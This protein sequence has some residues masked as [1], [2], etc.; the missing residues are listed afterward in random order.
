MSAN[1]W[2]YNEAGVLQWSAW[3]G[4]TARAMA[5]DSDGNV[6]VVGGRGGGK[7]VWKFDEDGNE[8]DS[9]DTGNNTAGCCLDGKGHLYVVGLQVSGKAVWKLDTSDMSLVWSVYAGTLARCVDYL[10]SEI[11]V[12]CHPNGTPVRDLR[13]FTEDGEV[14]YATLLTAGGIYAIKA[15]NYLWCGTL[16]GAL[17]KTNR[18]TG[19]AI[20]SYAP[21][22]AVYAV[23]QLPQV[24]YSYDDAGIIKY[25]KMT[26]AADG[27]MQK[28]H[29]M[30]GRILIGGAFVLMLHGVVYCNYTPVLA[31]ECEAPF[32]SNFS[33]MTITKS[34]NNK[35]YVA[36]INNSWSAGHTFWKLDLCMHCADTSYLCIEDWK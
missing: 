20:S 9:Y 1:V 3:T 12:G 33:V 32:V 22:S 15:S 23:E 4:D 25:Q 16:D 7:S 10:K 28:Y 14:V 26:D 31:G 11:Y 35:F 27:N 36:G 19:A 17:Q 21:F 8:V 6:Y 29:H 13:K 5:V 18:L 34:P 2:K 30:A 24:V